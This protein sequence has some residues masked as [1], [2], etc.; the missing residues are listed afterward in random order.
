M[1]GGGAS[2]VH[3]DI[4]FAK[5]FTITY[6]R[7][8]KVL[9]NIRSTKSYILQQCGTPDEY[10]NL[11]DEAVN[12]TVFKVP[13]KKWSSGLTTSYTFMGKL[14]LWPQAVVVDVHI[15]CSPCGRKLVDC[16]VI[17]APPTK[18]KKK[19]TAAV[20]ASGSQVHF[21]DYFN[22]SNTGLDIDVAF[23]ASSD[24]GV[25]SASPNTCMHTCTNAMHTTPH[26]SPQTSPP[27]LSGLLGRAEWIKFAAPFF[28]K[29]PEANSVFGAIE[30]RFEAVVKDVETAARGKTSPRV[31]FITKGEPDGTTFGSPGGVISI[32]AFKQEIVTKAGG[33]NVD[34]TIADTWCP[35]SVDGSNYKCA[36]ATAMKE[37]SSLE[38]NPFAVQSTSS[39]LSPP[40]LL[41]SHQRPTGAQNNRRRCR[42]VVYVCDDV[43]HAQDFQGEFQATLQQLPLPH[44]GPRLPHR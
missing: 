30:S 26:Q 15:M 3:E 41:L 12:A 38:S 22:T 33:T 43:V 35:L 14:G 21:T 18:P 40:L 34:R 13:L 5:D 31:A 27:H 42:R 1:V 39:A 9:K 17:S 32:A 8:Y 36:N 6:Y 7:T 20:V 37:V 4:T 29:E 16:G 11:P 19:W 28:N 44:F 24:P 25:S 2:T 10:P 23:D